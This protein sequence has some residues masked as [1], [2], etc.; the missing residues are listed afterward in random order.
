MAHFEQRE[1][2]QLPLVF[3]E[4]SVILA[5]PVYKVCKFIQS[6]Q[7]LQE[8]GVFGKKHV[9]TLSLWALNWQV[10]QVGLALPERKDVVYNRNRSKAAGL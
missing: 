7:L 10:S 4:A 1:V 2:F 8:L 5:G 6:S 9:W 3:E